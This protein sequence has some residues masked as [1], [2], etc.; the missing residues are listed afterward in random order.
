ML[1]T[2]S[3]PGTVP[4]TTAVVHCQLVNQAQLNAAVL[5][6]AGAAAAVLIEC[7]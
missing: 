7:K 3:V 4:T 6:S 5:G 2:A 1:T